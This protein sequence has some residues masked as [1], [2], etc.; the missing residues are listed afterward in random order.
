[1]ESSK[2]LNTKFQCVQNLKQ[3]HEDHIEEFEEDDLTKEFLSNFYDDAFKK[4]K[5]I[6]KKVKGIDEKYDQLIQYFGDTTKNMPID[7]FIEIFVKFSK[8]FNVNFS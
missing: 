3:L 8:E 1:L 2:E 5:D 6:E 4:I 7:T